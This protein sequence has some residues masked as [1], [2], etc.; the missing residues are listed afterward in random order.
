MP[1][2]VCVCTHC[3]T[4]EDS[5]ELDE[6]KDILWMLK[7]LRSVLTLRKRLFYS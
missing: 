6:L 5:S 1:I 2:C 7:S 3:G 4:F